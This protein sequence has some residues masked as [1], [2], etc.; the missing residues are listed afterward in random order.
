MDVIK[1]IDELKN[2][3]GWSDY[4]LAVKSGLSSSTIANMNRRKT[5]PSVATLETICNAFGITLSQFFGGECEN[6]VNITN[7]EYNMLT[8][9][10][11][12]DERQ[13]MLTMD[14]IKEFIS[15]Q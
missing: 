5:V 7:D 12:L 6:K 3:R 4:M 8:H 10:R 11:L 14:I 15:K 13:R 1:K 9:W 2:E